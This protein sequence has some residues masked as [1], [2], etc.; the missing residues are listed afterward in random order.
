MR[1]WNSD[2]RWAALL[3]AVLASSFIYNVLQSDGYL[4]VNNFVNIFELSIEKI[5]VVIAMTF[6]IVAGE[7]DLSVASI[8]VFSAAIIASLHAGG[9]LPFALVIV[10]ALMASAGAGFI[11]G[12]VITRLGLPSLV[13]T[14]AGLIAWRGAARVLVEDRSIGDFPIWFDT[15]GQKPLIGPI[16]F[17]LILFVVLLAAA[18][19]V[20]HRSKYGRYVYTIGDNSEVA[21][22]SGVRVDRIRTRL[23]VMSGLTAGLAGVLFTARLGSVRGDLANGFELEIITI[24]LL[25]GVSIFGGS[26]R[27]TG[28]ALAILVFLNVRN[29]LGLANLD[30]STQTGA[31][32]A[33]LII[34]VLARNGLDRIGTGTSKSPT[35]DP[36]PATNPVEAPHE[37]HQRA[38]RNQSTLRKE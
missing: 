10:I 6:V 32:G 29:G 27:M 24:V 19:V 17:S 38:P 7:I 20:L 18:G 30:G 1:S 35:S 16:P 31:I 9:S 5:I 36:Q 37:D 34:S 25:G 4:S 21:R 23:F 28:V 14:L 8:M 15:L 12:W 2:R 3:G 33:I 13:V 22:Y 26:G 11:Q